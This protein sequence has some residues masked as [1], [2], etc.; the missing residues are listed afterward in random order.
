MNSGGVKMALKLGATIETQEYS[1]S[2]IV[3]V[4]ILLHSIAH[5]QNSIYICTE[6]TGYF[7]LYR[8][9]SIVPKGKCF[10]TS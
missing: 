6:S 1:P 5:I 3:K 9:F 2:Q 8:N 7:L 4:P 10:N